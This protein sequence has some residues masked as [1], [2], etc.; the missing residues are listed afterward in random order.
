MSITS[1]RWN[2]ALIAIVFAA[3]AFHASCKKTA[4]SLVDDGGGRKPGDF[5]ELAADVFQ[6]MDGGLE[7]NSDEIKG[8][9]TWN[10]WCGGD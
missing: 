8:R 6:P 10:L 7:L 3:V 1:V 4:M 9:N 2:F 5:P